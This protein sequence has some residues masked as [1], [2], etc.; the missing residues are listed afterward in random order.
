MRGHAFAPRMMALTD[1]VQE[2]FEAFAEIAV[3]SRGELHGGKTCAAL[4]R[5]HSR[6]L[7]DHNEYEAT[8]MC[9][10]AAVQSA[11]TTS[12]RAFLLSFEW[13]EPYA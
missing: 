2:Q 7:F 5:Q 1:K 3:I 11:L 6:D 8:S 4:D 9:M 13:G 12:D 10:S